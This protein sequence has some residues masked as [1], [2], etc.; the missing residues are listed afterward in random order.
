[1]QQVRYSFVFFSKIRVHQCAHTLVKVFSQFLTY[2]QRC[3]DVNFQLFYPYVC[4][5]NLSS[6]SISISDTPVVFKAKLKMP[7]AES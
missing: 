2:H 7:F 5:I 4:N 6:S 1:M 3:I